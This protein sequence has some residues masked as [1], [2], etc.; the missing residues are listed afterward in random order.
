M[1]VLL[2]RKICIFPAVLTTFILLGISVSNAQTRYRGVTVSP[3]ISVDDIRDLSTWGVNVIRYSMTWNGPAD[4]ATREEYMAWLDQAMG[5]F[6]SLVVPLN[7]AKIKVVLNLYTPPGGF[8]ST[9]S[10]PYHRLFGEQWT[11]DAFREA[12]IKIAE[13][14]RGNPTV[15]AF[16]LVNEPAQK[17]VAKGLKNWRDLSEEVIGLIRSIDPD[18]PVIVESLYGNQGYFKALKK[19]P[20][21]N[22]IYSFHYYYPRKFQAQGINGG[23]INVKYPS[24]NCTKKTL[25]AFMNRVMSFQKKYKAEVYVGEF[26]AVRWAPGRSTYNYLRDLMN[27]FESRG[28]HWTY[29]AFRESDAWSVEHSGNRNDH[30]PTTEPTDRLLLLKG[31]FQRNAS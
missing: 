25:R 4:T 20:L 6:D 1:C 17:K 2:M 16:D 27:I 5:R 26:S 23:K 21:D 19:I 10:P 3:G 9:S 8:I 28:W 12:W 30:N 13:H 18:R 14:Y 22:I 7:E 31:F 24:R 11:Q 29:H 15:W